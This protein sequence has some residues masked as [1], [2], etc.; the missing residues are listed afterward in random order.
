MSNAKDT[1]SQRLAVITGGGRGIGR[2]ITLRLANSGWQCLTVGLEREDLEKTALLV[3]EKG[4]TLLFDECDIATEG[5]RAVVAALAE[6]SGCELGLLV[7][8]AARSTAMPLFEQSAETWCDELTTNVSAA[9]LLSSWAIETMKPRRRGAII[10]IGSVYG[11]LGLNSWF[12]DGIYPQDGP[13]GP[14]RSPAYHASKGAL[15]ALTRELA[16]VAGQWNIR[17]N[18]VSPGMIQTP[19][20]EVVPELLERFREGTPLQRLGQPEDIASVVRFLASEEAS[21]VTG[22]EWVV[23]GGWSI[24]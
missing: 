23:D 20:R 14:T 2:A 24:W 3:E 21:F 13:A 5:G 4:H 22:A 8:C 12:Y 18:T 15:A 11:S 17:V 9:A 19:E 7:N 10:N 16:V 6:G 1:T